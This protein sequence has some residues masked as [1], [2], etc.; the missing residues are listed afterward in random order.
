LRTQKFVARPRKQKYYNKKCDK[1]QISA[2]GGIESLDIPRPE[3][4]YR[5]P[6]VSACLPRL[7]S[8]MRLALAKQ[9]VI[10]ITVQGGPTSVK[11]HFG[12][13]FSGAESEKEKIFENFC[14]ES[15]FREGGY[16]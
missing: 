13:L 7:K 14:C 4:F 11:L 1:V 5:S 2:R 6:E 9:S 8:M 16:Q 10:L 3:A 12:S 15:Y